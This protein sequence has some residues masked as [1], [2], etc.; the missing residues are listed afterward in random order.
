VDERTRL[1]GESSSVGLLALCTTFVF[2]TLVEL[3]VTA[4]FTR[5]YAVISTWLLLGTVGL[6]FFGFNAS[7]AVEPLFGRALID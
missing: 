4:D 2:M 3:P 6:A 1:P 7:R 5:P